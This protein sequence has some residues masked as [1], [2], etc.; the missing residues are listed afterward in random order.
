MFATF[1]III[2]Y[3]LSSILSHLSYGQEQNEYDVII[4]GAGSA[5]IAAATT[6]Y[7]ANIT[8]ILIIAAMDYIGGRTKIVNLSNYMLGIGATWISG[9]CINRTNCSSNY[10]QI[11][12]MLTAAYKY[13]I[14]FIIGGRGNIILD[15][16][17]I[18]HNRTNSNNRRNKFREAQS[19]S[20]NISNDM[21]YD[22]S[23]FAAY[24][25]CGW[26]P[27]HQSIDKTISVDAEQH[28]KWRTAFLDN[29]YVN[30][31]STFGPDS[32]FITDQRGY[33]GIIEALA[34]EFLDIDNINDEAKIILNSPITT[35]QYD[36][37][38]VTV[39]LDEDNNN[40][41]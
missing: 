29:E 14:S 18:E 4:M 40:V 15:F 2:I 30:T 1:T 27:P 21:S 41:Q 25:L 19:C 13:N 7:E 38:G 12:P 35:I 10:K 17:G 11:N 39:T 31:Y 34:G 6:L 26:K 22:M 37:N 9:A 32:P 3:V 5:G 23:K 8:N 36:E 33:Q 28:K 24:N 16:G 20:N